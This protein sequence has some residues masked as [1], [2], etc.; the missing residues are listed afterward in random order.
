MNILNGPQPDHT[1][2]SDPQLQP[3]DQ[4][5]QHPDRKQPRTQPAPC[6]P[7]L[8]DVRPLSLATAPEAP[9]ALRWP[10]DIPPRHSLH[11]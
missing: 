5:T 6:G 10:W 1:Q 2:N 3:P 11:R 9:E 8:Q 7:D 4:N